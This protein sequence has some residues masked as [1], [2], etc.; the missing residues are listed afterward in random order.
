MAKFEVLNELTLKVTMETNESI[1]AKAGAMIG[2]QGDMKFDKLDSCKRLVIIDDEL[3]T[4]STALNLIDSIE[5]KYKINEFTSVEVWSLLNGMDSR[6]RQRDKSRGINLVYL[7]EV[8]K[9]EVEKHAA[10]LDTGIKITPVGN[11]R[12]VIT[13]ASVELTCVDVRRGV[14]VRYSLERQVSYGKKIRIYRFIQESQSVRP[15]CCGKTDKSG[16]F[17]WFCK[18]G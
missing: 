10:T 2:F 16:P 11:R 18:K 9:T 15:I 3:S 1:H 5:E 13:T 12:P 4:G 17:L 7:E 14:D 6:D 8:N